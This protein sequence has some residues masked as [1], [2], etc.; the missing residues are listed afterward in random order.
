M[1]DE[2]DNAYEYPIDSKQHEIVR[3]NILDKP[4]DSEPR[5]YPR[6]NHTEQEQQTIIDTQ[7]VQVPH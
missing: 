3:S 4:F 6:A 7:T 1:G 2:N 5:N